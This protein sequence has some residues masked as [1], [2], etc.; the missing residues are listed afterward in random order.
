MVLAA[1]RKVLLA[2]STV[3]SVLGNEG[4]ASVSKP[5]LPVPLAARVALMVLAD[6]RQVSARLSRSC[7]V[8]AM[9]G[10]LLKSDVDVEGRMRDGVVRERSGQVDYM[11]ALDLGSTLSNVPLLPSHPSIHPPSVVPTQALPL[12][13]NPPHSLIKHH[14]AF[15]QHH[16]LR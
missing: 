13:Q 11:W 16:T 8:T 10:K 1:A 14:S 9:A 6:W 3:S 5:S 15:L 12:P 4:S 2:L 7:D